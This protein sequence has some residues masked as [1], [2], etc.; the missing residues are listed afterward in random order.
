MPK[1]TFGRVGIPWAGEAQLEV[2]GDRSADN[3]SITKVF[4][5]TEIDTVGKDPVFLRQCRL[6]IPLVGVQFI[7]VNR[8][9]RFFLSYAGSDGEIPLVPGAVATTVQGVGVDHFSLR[10]VNE[11]GTALAANAAGK[12]TVVVVDDGS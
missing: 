2:S 1:P 12:V 11:D 6:R 8:N 9:L 7:N 4:S 10:M 3:L 5:F